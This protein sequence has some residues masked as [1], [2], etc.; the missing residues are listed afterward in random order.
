MDVETIREELKNLAEH[1]KGE[2][3]AN[4]YEYIWNIVNTIDG[5]EE[6]HCSECG[7]TLMH[8]EEKE[9]TYCMQCEALKNGTGNNKPSKKNSRR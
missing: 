7:I 4:V 3:S 8:K 2:M 6:D 1:K 9:D 5:D